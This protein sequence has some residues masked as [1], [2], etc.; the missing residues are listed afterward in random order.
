MAKTKTEK[1]TAWL[2]ERS[3]GNYLCRGRDLAFDWGPRLVA[4]RFARREDAEAL[5]LSLADVYNAWDHEGDYTESSLGRPYHFTQSLRACSVT[6][7]DQ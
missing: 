6:E 3:P 4:L 5:R 1:S 7:I 2:I